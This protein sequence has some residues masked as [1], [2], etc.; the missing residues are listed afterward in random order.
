MQLTSYLAFNGQCEEAFR[1][2]EQALGGKIG[3]MVP[4][5]G[6]PAEQSV[7]P[8]WK[9]KIMHARLDLNGAVLMG[10]DAPPNHYH[11]PTGFSVSLQVKDPVEAERFFKA[12]SEN[13]TVQMPI[14]QTFFSPRFGMLIDQFGIPWMINCEP[15]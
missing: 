10:G 9:K 4:H 8:E 13:G 11:K 2:Y 7:P 1:F 6:S 3:A 14:Q 15:A 12:L 5:E